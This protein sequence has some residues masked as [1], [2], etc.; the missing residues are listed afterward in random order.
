[1]GTYGILDWGVFALAAPVLSWVF[2]GILLIVLVVKQLQIHPRPTKLRYPV[3]KLVLVI[4]AWNIIPF[5]A[6]YMTA[7]YAASIVSSI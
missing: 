1:M 7:D 5:V 6:S 4:L 2:A 3:V